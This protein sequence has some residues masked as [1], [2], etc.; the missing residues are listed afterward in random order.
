LRAVD[1]IKSLEKIMEFILVRA[2]LF[3]GKQKK[4]LNECIDTGSIHSKYPFIKSGKV[5][6]HTSGDWQWF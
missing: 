2:A 5:Q 3:D 1:L 4:Y 6:L